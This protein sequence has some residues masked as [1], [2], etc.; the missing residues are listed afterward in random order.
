VSEHEAAVA[1]ER[2]LAVTQASYE[3]RAQLRT[4]LDSRVVIEQAKGI[5]AERFDLSTEDAFALIRYSARSAQVSVQQL[6]SEIAPGTAT[7]GPVLVGLAR[8]QRWR[9][10]AQ[11]EQAEH[12]RERAHEQI[13]RAE[14]VRRTRRA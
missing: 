8:G 4:A 3:R 10:A 6:C 1:V 5:L 14:R 9:A 13:A 7:P 11:R 12:Q 2:L